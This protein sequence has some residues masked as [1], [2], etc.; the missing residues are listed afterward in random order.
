M[1]N[2]WIEMPL[3]E[4]FK[5]HTLLK[6]ERENYNTAWYEEGILVNVTPRNEEISLYE[7]RGIAYNARYIVLNGNKYDLFDPVDIM[8]MEIPSQRKNRYNNASTYEMDEIAIGVAFSDVTKEL[9]YH[10]QMR[11]KRIFSRELVVP[12]VFK[13]INMLITWQ[14]AER[15]ICD[16]MIAQLYAV[17]ADEYADYLETELRRVMPYYDDVDHHSKVAFDRALEM[18]KKLGHNL[19]EL[20]YQAC[21]CEECA[22]YMGRIYSIDG[23][24]KRFPRLPEFIIKKRQIHER[25]H[26]SFFSCYYYEGKKLD[27][28]VFKNVDDVISVPVDALESS[29]RPFVDDRSEFAKKRYLQSVEREKIENNLPKKNYPLDICMRWMH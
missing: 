6:K 22:K 4:E 21:A 26:C 14:V 7:D 17:G 28:W 11:V 27:K 15:K 8:N 1:E 9:W 19:L 13:T 23:E 2:V 3:Y 25:C 24:D 18:T 29:N 5:Q 10:L 16:R 12:L 20:Q